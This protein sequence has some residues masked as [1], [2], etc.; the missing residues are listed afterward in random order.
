ELIYV[1]SKLIYYIIIKPLSLIPLWMLYFISDGIFFILYYLTPY[2][3]KIVFTNLHN[4]FPEKS[5]QEI[6]KISKKFYRHFTDLIAESIRMFSMP[7]H[8]VLRR[9]KIEDT[10][11][12]NDLYKKGKSI[13]ITGGHY[14]NWE[15][16]ALAINQQIP[17]Q[18]AALYTPMRNIFFNTT[19]LNSRSRFGVIMV[20]KKKV[21]NFFNAQL[22]NL[23][24]TLFGSDQ[25]PSMHSKSYYRTRFLNQETAVLFGT[26]KY[27]IEYNYPVVF[28]H[29]QKIKRGHYLATSQLIELNP[30]KTAYGEITG[31]HTALLEKEIINKPE[32]WLWSHKRWKIKFEK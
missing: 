30:Q 23:T 25:S 29:I 14:N 17:H 24:A 20:H 27:A 6:E 3:K 7:E 26:E 12:F 13:I 11:L 9:F 15:M 4:A 16:L 31:K 8:E 22:L 28:M 21:K 2:R 5:K 19:F 32:Y 18:V 1:M 10:D